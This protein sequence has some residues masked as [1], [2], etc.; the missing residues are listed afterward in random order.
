MTGS[1]SRT[2]TKT[3]LGASDTMVYNKSR[4]PVLILDNVTGGALTP[5]IDGAGGS[6]VPVAGVGTVSVASGL[7]LSSLAAGACVAIPL[8]SIEAYLQGVI[9]VTGGTGIKAS[10][11]E[12]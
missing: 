8:E 2:L 12:F 3:T 11:L 1:G 5:N 4:K 6:T 9:T 10:I 7:T